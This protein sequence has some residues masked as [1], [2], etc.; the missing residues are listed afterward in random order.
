VKPTLVFLVLFGAATLV[1]ADQAATNVATLEDFYG[2]TG[3]QFRAAVGFRTAE[4]VDHEAASIG[5]G[6]AVDDM[7]ISWKETRLDPDTHDCAG[8]GECALLETASSEAFEGNSI[9]SLTVTDRTPYDPVNPRHDCNGDGD[10][11]DPGDDQDCNDNGL[12]D[13][14]VKLTSAAEV[15][16]EIAVL[17]QVTPGSPIYKTNFPYSTFYNSPGTLFA[18]QQGSA[19][20][21]ITARYEDRNDGTGGR[22]KNALQ[23]SQEGFVTATT[24]VHITSGRIAVQSYTVNNVSVCSINAAKQCTQN[25]DCLAGEGLCNSCS[26]LPAKPC[27]PGATSGANACITGQGVCTSTAGRGD[28]DGFADTNE[29]IALAVAFT[30]KSGVDIDGLTATLGTASQNIECVT[31]ATI[32]VGSLADGATSDPA[33]YP[34]FQFKVANVN[35]TSVG[36]VLQAAFSIT[37]RSSK[38][39]ALTRVETITLDL[40]FSVTGSATTSAFVEDFENLP[41]AGLGKFTRDTLDAGRFSSQLSDGFRCQYVDP[42]GLNSFRESQ[43]CFLGFTGDPATGVNDW[44]IHTSTHAR[45]GRAF[46][47]KQSVHMGIHINGASPD[48]DTYRLKQLDAIKTIN[49]VAMPLPNA[50]PE[51]TFA[52]QISLVDN[53]AGV[54]VTAGETL[55][56]GV[57]EVQ[58]SETGLAV[59]SWIKIYPYYNLYDQQGENDFSNCVFDP[60][61][62]GND[63]D[64]FFDPTDP[65]RL[66]GPSSTCWPE[67][68]FARQG[69][70]HYLKLFDPSDIGLASDGPGLQGCSGAGCLPANVPGTISN[71]GTWVRPRFSLK[72]FA[73]R[74]IRIRFLFTSIEV[75][76]TQ[77]MNLFFGR[78]NVIGDDGWYIDDIHIDQALATPLTISPDTATI[79]PIPCGAC[80]AIAPALVANPSTSSGPGQI[81]TLDG[82]SSTVDRCLNGIV[83]F[84]FWIDANGN[85]IVGDGGDALLR[86]WTDNS[87]LIDA[88]LITTQYGMRSRCSTDTTCDSA[89]NSIVLSV[90]VTCP[91]T[92]TLS[93][94]GIRVGKTAGFGGSE[95]DSN[96]TITGW[97]G[98][99]TVSIVRGD[100]NALRSSGGVTNVETGGCVAN[101][102]F[103]ASVADVSPL[104]AGAGKYFLLKTPPACNVAGSGTYSENQP[105]EFAGA[106]GNRNSD[107]SA[108]P[109]SCP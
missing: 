73:G 64:S 48:L 37:M 49:A 20:P 40:D 39:D 70:T 58:L 65:D 45:M 9:V 25:T 105:T 2:D 108:D 11:V 36:Q 21:Q 43:R 24:D 22:C 72:Q 57:V 60:I 91:S 86:D 50:N 51:L 94:A 23:P 32:F 31:R 10:Y 29:T 19:P 44:H 12:P 98:N 63:E 88:P 47:G 38:F 99:L 76:D 4:P 53:S 83:Q 75:G 102:T 6:I 62:D 84:Q 8:S 55:D 69:Q 89:T 79:T 109:D 41:S 5:F 17:D 67:F 30:N 77:T 66:Y 97:G 16:G 27:I 52:Q 81:V 15:D 101:A 18:Q 106:G 26:L 92:S 93:V 85:G 107:V 104:P 68:V 78:P 71:P 13:V 35:R 34:P 42:F 3:N 103:A 28:P 95:P 14:T 33:T 96:V 74:A 90:P 100:L 46:T 87:T 54:N 56:R 59:G 80:A 7:V 82:R 1:A 61:D